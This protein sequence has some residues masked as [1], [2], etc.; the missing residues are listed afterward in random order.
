[1]DPG[2]GPPRHPGTKI[3]AL[4]T[5]SAWIFLVRAHACRAGRR[6]SRQRY[7]YPGEGPATTTRRWSGGDAIQVPGGSPSRSRA[8]LRLPPGVRQGARRRRWCEGEQPHT[9]SW[10]SAVA[11]DAEWM[12]G[13]SRFRLALVL[14]EASSWRSDRRAQG[15]RRRD[16]SRFIGKAV[17]SN[18]DEPGQFASVR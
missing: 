7:F 18:R 2:G 3:R 15:P 17:A 8:G 6:F 12:S 10:R 14:T 16:P 1:V 11:D 13:E 9:L 4:G 5:S